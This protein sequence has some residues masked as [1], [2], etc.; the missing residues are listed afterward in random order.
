MEQLNRIDA[1]F[2]ETL[3]KSD[4]RNVTYD[5]A[6][7]ILDSVLHEGILKDISVDGTVVG[8]GKNAIR[9]KDNLFLKKLI[10]FLKG[11]GK[12]SPSKKRDM[13]I[14]H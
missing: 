13:V 4:L 6:E 8:L 5:W 7:T 10:F 1:P 3:K 12:V 2:S 11:I 14:Q 9:I